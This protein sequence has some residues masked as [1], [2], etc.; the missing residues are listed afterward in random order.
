[1]LDQQDNYLTSS[2]RSIARNLQKI[3]SLAA[4]T[5][6]DRLANP[7]HGLDNARSILD[8]SSPYEVGLG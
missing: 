3:I 7:S 6:A 8:F 2:V 5:L 4:G 1:M